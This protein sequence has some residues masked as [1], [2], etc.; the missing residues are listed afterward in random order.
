MLPAQRGN[1]GEQ[2]IGQSFG[3]GAKLS[4]GVA[5]VDGM[6]PRLARVATSRSRRSR[7]S[8][9][10]SRQA[11]KR[12]GTASPNSSAFRLAAKAAGRQQEVVEGPKGSTALDPD[13][14]GTKPI[15][16]RHHHSNLPGATVNNRPHPDQ[17]APHRRQKGGRDPC[18]ELPL[19][20]SVELAQRLKGGEQGIGRFPRAERESSENDRRSPVYPGIAFDHLS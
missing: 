14:S 12:S 1:V 19:P 10:S 7:A 3:L 15:P 9:R 13:I 16:K 2:V 6:L 4:N 8:R 18:W 20:G 5:E 11:S 17:L